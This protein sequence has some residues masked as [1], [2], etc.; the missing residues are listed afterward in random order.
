[1]SIEFEDEYADE[2][3]RVGEDGFRSD[4]VLYSSDWTTETI[5]SQLEKKN[6][7]VNP[8]FQRRDA[9][10]LTKKSRLIESIILG[11]PIPQIVFAEKKE[12]R[13][14]YIV[15]DGKQRLTT[16]LKFIGIG[17]GKHNSFSLKNLQ[18][19]PELNGCSYEELTSNSNHI[20]HLTNFSN[21]TIRSVIIKN[22]ISNDFLNLIF[23]RLNTGSVKLSPQ[24]LRQALFPG[25]FTNF[26]EQFSSKSKQL[27]K[28]LKITEPDF[29]MRDVELFVRYIAFT[30]RYAQYAGDM[31]NF[32]DT[33]CEFYNENWDA[34]KDEVN[35]LA[36]EFDNAIET[37]FEIFGKDFSRKWSGDKAEGALNRAI[38]DVMLFYFSNRHVR[39][40]MLRKSDIIKSKFIEI[41]NDNREFRTSIEQTT[42]SL[43]A[44]SDRY[45][46]WGKALTEIVDIEI[47][48]LRLGMTNRLIRTSKER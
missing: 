35:S 27:S 38:L 2:Q 8:H 3:D 40:A 37:G 46:L 17:E 18:I 26:A 33:T 7:D 15:L 20:D 24:E 19:L 22:W 16:L 44:T 9:W 42:K 47:E 32:L 11:L 43:T 45:F 36:T 13:G 23:V 14:K 41:C 29:R 25:K 39:D 31:K 6:I 10:D 4:A 5:I 30:T 28:L 1:M 21:H 12:A 34:R 48:Y